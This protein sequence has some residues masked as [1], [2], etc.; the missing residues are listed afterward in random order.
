MKITVII[1]SFYLA[2]LTVLP[3]SDVHVPVN[4]SQVEIVM[5]ID[6]DHSQNGATDLCS[7]FCTCHCCQVLTID[8]EMMNFDAE[9]P[10]ISKQ[11]FGHFESI[12]KDFNPS[13]LQPP[14]V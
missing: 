7:L 12:G 10:E 1:L 4:D 6:V 2:A 8:F 5:D 3:C 14:R 13:L 9:V 11:V